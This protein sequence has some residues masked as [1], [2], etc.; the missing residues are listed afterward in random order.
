MCCSEDEMPSLFLVKRVLNA[1]HDFATKHLST[2][3]H[4][5]QGSTESLSGKQH[6]VC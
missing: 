5:S 2:D 6:R 1:V 3:V 4:V